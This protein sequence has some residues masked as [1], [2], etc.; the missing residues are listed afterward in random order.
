MLD[1]MAIKNQQEMI[2]SLGEEAKN[3]QTNQE[4]GDLGE[5]ITAREIVQKTLKLNPKKIFISENEA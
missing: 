1:F 2:L 4:N 5:C 3:T